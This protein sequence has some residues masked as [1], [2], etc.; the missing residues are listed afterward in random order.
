METLPAL[1]Q[2]LPQAEIARL[3]DAFKRANGPVMT[4]VNKL[5]GSF[6]TQLAMIPPAYRSQMERTVA[7]AL[8]TSYS[9]A[10]QA[11]RLPDAGPRGRMA[12]AMATGAAGGAGGI[13]TALAELPLTITLILNAIR[14]EARAA[15]FDPDA[16]EIRAECIRTFGAGS[17]MASDDGI[18]TSFLSARLTLTGPAVQKVIATVAPKLAAV[19]GQKLAAQAVPV[20]GA[21]AG[22]GLNAAFLSYYREMARIRFA[23][24]RLAQS[25][26]ADRVLTEFMAAAGQPRLKRA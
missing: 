6:E 4:L 26:G 5:G 10:G 25:H 16:P 2:D 24:L 14:A 15:G 9:V 19:L 7:L 17:P 20:L 22:A 21:L 18:N 8:S 3:A 23:L 1:P 13:A 11:D 12:A